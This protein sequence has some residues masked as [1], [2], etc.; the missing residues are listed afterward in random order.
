MDSYM[1]R[2]SVSLFVSGMVLFWLV[3]PAVFAYAILIADT[4]SPDATK[5]GVPL[6]FVGGGLAFVGV[7]CFFVCAIR[8]LKTIDFLG[9]RE[10]ARM[11]AEEGSAG[12]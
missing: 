4:P 3:G 2:N 7:I 1:P 11:E 10:A 6:M 5:I 12:C 9:R 8:A